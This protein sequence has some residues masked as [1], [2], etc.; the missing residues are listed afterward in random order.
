M[1]SAGWEGAASWA[2][3]A[4]RIAPTIVGGSKKHG[5]PDLG[6]TRAK[7]AWSKLGVDAHGIANEPPA[8]GFVGNPKLTV[9][10]VASLQGFPE[11]WHFAGGKT[12]AYRQVGNAFPPP[13][14]E[15]VGRRIALA[16]KSTSRHAVCV[17]QP[18]PVN[19]SLV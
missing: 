7:I 13:V 18:L 19:S 14:A 16:L 6:P 3:G 17:S 8:P 12:S 1:A 11:D 4:H 9:D 10:M 2:S 5:G 15:A